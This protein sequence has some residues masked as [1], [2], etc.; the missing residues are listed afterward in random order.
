MSVAQNPWADSEGPS[1]PPTTPPTTTTSNSIY[2]T[3]LTISQSAR[4]DRL[5]KT[6]EHCRVIKSRSN[7]VELV[8][9]VGSL[10]CNPLF[11]KLNLEQEILNC[12]SWL[13]SSGKQYRDMPKYIGKW[14]RRAVKT[15]PVLNANA[16]PTESK[17][18]H[19]HQVRR[20]WP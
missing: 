11:D 6:L 8:K 2:I 20:I 1:P 5:S 12:E 18:N 14:M 10:V 17:Y 13:D 16:P 3:G 4:V 19:L 7:N 9:I 15:K